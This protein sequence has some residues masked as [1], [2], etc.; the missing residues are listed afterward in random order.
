ME[1]D[2]VYALDIIVSE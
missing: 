1:I 2:G